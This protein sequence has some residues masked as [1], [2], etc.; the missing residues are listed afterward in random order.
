MGHR[1]GPCEGP[2]RA[3]GPAL[4][5]AVRAVVDVGLRRAQLF[6]E[7]GQDAD[8]PFDGGDLLGQQRLQR[9]LDAGAG[10]RVGE[11][12]EAADLGQFESEPLG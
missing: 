10:A 9:D 3:L 8:L 1:R 5:V 2:E 11:L 4:L 7:Y 12:Q 6:L